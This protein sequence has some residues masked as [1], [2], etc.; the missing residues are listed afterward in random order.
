MIA[1][2]PEKRKAWEI[3]QDN[4]SM[5]SIPLCIRNVTNTNKRALQVAR[6]D[7]VKSIPPNI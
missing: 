7:F 4:N 2:N 3:K 1:I 5:H 6:L